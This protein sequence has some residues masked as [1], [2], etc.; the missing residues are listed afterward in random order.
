MAGWAMRACGMAVIVGAVVMGSTTVISRAPIEAAPK[1][2]KLA[3]NLVLTGGWAPFGVGMYNSFKLAVDQAT[4]GGEFKDVKVEVT[5][6][7]NTGD[8]AQGVSRA[9]KAGQDPDV[10]GAVCCWASGIGVATHSVYNRYAL[11]VIL[12][13]SND[14][15][16]SRPFHQ[17]KVVFRNSPYDLINMKMAAVYAV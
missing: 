3:T 4:A 17:S 5:R 12:G 6:G 9:T 11:P 14:H 7:D 16:S 15:R 10:V 13:G 8:T 2:C 1:S